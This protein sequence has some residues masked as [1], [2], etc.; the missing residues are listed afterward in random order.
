[1]AAMATIMF[2]GGWLEPSLPAWLWLGLAF[3]AVVVVVLLIASGAARE[4]LMRPIL[5]VGVLVAALG[6]IM[7]FGVNAG[8]S[9]VLPSVVWFFAKMFA[10]V[11]F[12]IWMRWTYPRLRLDQLLNLSW[13]VLLPAGLLNLLITGFLITIAR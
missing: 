1:M 3:V 10:L 9:P 6:V 2:L 11:F 5:V 13:K 12:L 8:R 4:L 7:F